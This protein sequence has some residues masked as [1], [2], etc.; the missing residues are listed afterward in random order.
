MFNKYKKMSMFRLVFRTVEILLNYIGLPQISINS[1]VSA[2]PHVLPCSFERS[3]E[4]DKFDTLL[5]LD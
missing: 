5:C 4:T 3:T 2:S 1:F